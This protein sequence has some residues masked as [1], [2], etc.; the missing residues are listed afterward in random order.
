M[1]ITNNNKNYVNK[2]REI[3]N[4]VEGTDFINISNSSKSQLGIMLNTRH[5]FNFETLSGQTNSI[6]NFINYACFEHN[7]DALIGFV[8]KHPLPRIKVTNYWGIVAYALCEKVHQNKT[9]AK[10]LKE[11]ELP[12]YILNLVDSSSFVSEKK[13][14]ELN[15]G[16]KNYV[17]IINQIS[18]LL[19]NDSFNKE[20]ILKLIRSFSK[21]D[22]I[23]E[24]SNITETLNIPKT[25]NAKVEASET[26]VEQEE[27]DIEAE[28]KDI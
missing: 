17:F 26:N 27:F 5:K 21:T 3:N 9:L 15:K 2:N 20:N 6:S 18:K 8:P 10:L 1:L 22:N 16:M 19:K 13:N 28:G 14:F 7:R 11:N 12:I 24:N 4:L 25:I 23:F